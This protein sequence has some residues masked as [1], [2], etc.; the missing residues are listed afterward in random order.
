MPRIE[1]S[2]KRMPAMAASAAPTTNVTGL[3]ELVVGDVY[4]AT[5]TGVAYIV[6]ATN[7]TSTIAFAVIGG[8][9]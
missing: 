7:K 3:G 2:V 8:Q 9:V 5:S 4:V 1:G 6:T